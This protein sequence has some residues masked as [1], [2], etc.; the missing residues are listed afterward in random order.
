MTWDDAYKQLE[1][2]LGREPN[3]VEVQRRLLEMV[4]FSIQD[5]ETNSDPQ[6]HHINR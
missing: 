2:E 5:A 4:E 3:V 1:Q 6:V